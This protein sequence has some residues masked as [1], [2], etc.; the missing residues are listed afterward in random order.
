MS[1][2]VVGCRSS[3]TIEPAATS[4]QEDPLP[5]AG[6]DLA[7]EVVA[8]GLVNP[9]GLA[10]LP[11]GR[12]L[13]AEEGSGEDDL[14]AGVS[15]LMPDGSIGR[16][17]SG[18]PSGRD[19]GDLS[20]VPLVGVSPDGTT[21]YT[22]HFGSGRLLTV[23]VGRLSI[24]TPL[25]PDDLSSAMRPLNSVTLTNPFDITFDS[26]GVPVVSD[27][28][29]NGVAI[30]TDGGRTRF[31]H[32]FDRL[33][34]PDNPDLSIDP[35]PTG[36]S[37][38]D[39]EYLVTLTGGCPYP[40]GS[41]RLVAVDDQRN[42]RT[43]V[44]GLS[45]PIDIALDE[46]GAIWILEFAR[47]E[48]DASCFSGE[49]Y[50]P[51]T[52]RI[53]RLSDTGVREIVLDELDFP[54]SILVVGDVMW[55]SEVFSGRILR[56]SQPGAGN[57]SGEP[58]APS[59]QFVD[60]TADSGIQFHHGAFPEMIS[61]DPAAMMGAGLCWIDYDNDGWLDLYL[62]NSHAPADVA[63]W[64]SNGGLPTNT[65][66]RNRRGSFEDV[67]EETGTG[68]TMV[69]NGCLA[70]DL[71]NDGWTDLYLTADGADVVLRNDGDGRFVDVSNETGVDAPEWNTA[72]VAGDLNGD[73]LLELFVGSYI[74][75]GRKIAKPSGAFPQDF[76]GIPDRLY[77][78]ESRDGEIRF[79]DIGAAA[80]LAYDERALGALFSDVDRDG[81]LDLYI[82]NDGQ[83]NRLYENRPGDEFGFT[84]VD[85]TADAGVGDTGSGMGVAGGD[86]DGDGA[87][88]LFVTNWEAELNALYHNSGDLEFLYATHRIGI[89]GLGNNKTAWGATW[90]D[91]DLDTDLDL[92]VAHG[93]VPVTDLDSDPELMRFY[94]NLGSDGS[95]GQFRDHTSQSGL[96]SIGPLLARGSAVADFDNDGDLDVA[97]NTIAGS[98]RLLRNETSGNWLV[99][100]GLPAGS[101]VTVTLPDRTALMRERHVGSSYLATEDPRVHFGLG[102]HDEV[103]V[104]VLFPDQT[105]VVTERVAANQV[106]TPQRP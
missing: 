18:L 1:L 24:D 40:P 20:G 26:A 59:Q 94:V 7:V 76:V 104:H 42:Q 15:M 14:S 31:F 63:Y 64:Q 11:D 86:Y 67:S 96:A 43:V 103:T 66:Y 9:L 89:A 45:M 23:P 13:I 49:G 21:A 68:L 30:E 36:I 39:G 50:L 8:D 78:N 57:A 106:L 2:L 98:A 91:I 37:R 81:D 61:D 97:V 47:F 71:D 60:A 105:S 38:V 74:D 48:E 3:T 77:L 5:N 16:V 65:L 33:E 58:P 34:N 90:A 29:Q 46:D 72:A 73:G 92:L 55:V 62:M 44:E 22:A 27:A 102:D 75:L 54:G 10:A 28:S 17:I 84:L 19:S 87:F 99:V 69:G 32:R 100:A 51:G 79:T 12:I 35:V 25:G 82:A 56:I 88:D 85:V 95:P 101:V 6:L 53:S 41:G 4:A 83:A 80:G 52:G 93:R 70:A